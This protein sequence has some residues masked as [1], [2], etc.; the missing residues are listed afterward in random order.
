MALLVAA[1]LAPPATRA[2]A[3]G[4][5][6]HLMVASRQLDAC[7]VGRVAR[8]RARP[9]ALAAVNVRLLWFLRCGAV[10]AV[11][12]VHDGVCA[13]TCC[14]APLCRVPRWCRGASGRLACGRTRRRPESKRCN[15]GLF[16]CRRRSRSPPQRQR[17]RCR[18]CFAREV[19]PHRSLALRMRLLARSSLR[20]LCAALCRMSLLLCLTAR[21][22]GWHSWHADL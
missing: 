8:A 20:Q 12:R 16:L 17:R 9:V 3:R 5:V 19:R 13:K 1:R 2:A 10:A 18:R 15:A 21:F 11:C 6:K 22:V 4:I 7:G 14:P